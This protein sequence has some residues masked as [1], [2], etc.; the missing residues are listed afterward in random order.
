MSQPT[1][2]L[3]LVNVHLD[4]GSTLSSAGSGSPASRPASLRG[5]SF[6]L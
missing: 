1:G 4:N 5:G 6:E 2:A 3:A